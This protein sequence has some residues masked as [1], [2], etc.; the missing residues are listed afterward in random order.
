[1]GQGI[2]YFFTLE[3]TYLFWKKSDIK[4]KEVQICNFCL[5]HIWSMLVLIS[6]RVSDAE[7]SKKYWFLD[8]WYKSDR[9]SSLLFNGLFRG[10]GNEWMHGGM[11]KGNIKCEWINQQAKLQKNLHWRLPKEVF[12]VEIRPRGDKSYFKKNLSSGK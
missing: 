6:S 3:T 11:N 8:H 10:I 9:Q 2:R 4:R 7:E 12:T 1:M 5:Y